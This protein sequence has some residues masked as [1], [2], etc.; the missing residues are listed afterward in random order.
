VLGLCFSPKGRMTRDS[1]F[2]GTLITWLI[3]SMGCLALAIA[4][5]SP[6]SFQVFGQFLDHRGQALDAMFNMAGPVAVGA[7]LLLWL[8][9]VWSLV[10]MSVKRLQ[11]V[12]QSGWFAL[13]SFVPGVQILFW[14]ALCAW[15]DRSLRSEEALSA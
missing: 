12:G 13:L 15:P 4:T 5:T 10:V 14:L 1:F 6:Y 9:Q 3:G 2:L 7:T 8:G 11:T